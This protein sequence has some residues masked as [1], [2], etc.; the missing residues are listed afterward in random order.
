MKK[1]ITFL[2]ILLMAGISFAWAQNSTVTGTVSDKTGASLPG[3]TVRVKGTQTGTLT[4]VN[5]KYSISAPS[6]AVLIFSFIGF[7]T[8]EVPVGNQTFINVTLQEST[9]GLNEVVVVGYGTQTKAL[10]TGAISTVSAK[11]LQDQQIT[12][13]DDALQGRAAGVYVVQSSGAPGAG[14]SVTIRGSNSLINSSPLYV[15]DGVV[16]DNGG[17]DLVNPN[18]VESINVLKD[19]SAAIYGSRASNGVILITTKKGRSGTPKITYDFYYGTQS[20]M[21]KIGLANGTQYATLRNEAVTNDGGTAPFANPSSFGVGTNWQDLIFGNAPIQSQTLSISGGSETSNYYTSIGYLD[22]KGIVEPSASDYKRLNLKV[23]ATLHPKK[24]F[25]LG[26]NFSYSYSRST[27]FFNTNSEFGG[28]L[29]DAINLDPLTPAV[30]TDINSQPNAATYNN[31]AQFIVRNSLGQP[32]GISA[33]V[34][35]EIVNPLAAIQNVTGNYNW[36]HNLVGDIYVEIEPVKGL[37]LRTEIAGKQAFYG[38][39]AFTPLYYLNQQ[40]SNLITTTQ[41]RSSNQNL[42]WNWDNTATYSRSFGLHSVT[43]LIGASAEEESGRGDNI[44]FIGEP[45]F[46]SATAS[47]NYSLPVASRQAGGFDSQPLTRASEF[48]RVNYDYD[49]KYLFTGIVRRDGSSKFGSDRIYGVFPSGQLGWVASKEKFFPKDAFVSYLKVRASYG[50]LGNELA[51][52]E[53]YFTPIISGGGGGSTVINNQL[54]NGLGPNTLANPLLQWERTKSTDIA[55][56]AILFRDFNL[57][58]DIYDKKT[59]NLIEQQ[60]LPAY[61]GLSS[62]PYSNVGGIDNK[63]IE[64]ELGYNKKI[65]NDLG[66]SFNG[67]LS[68]NK[69]SVTSLGILQF[70]DF[71]SFQSSAYSLQRNVVGQPQNSFYGFQTI[72]IFQSQAEINAY[73]DAAGNVIQP[74]AK[75]GDF[76]FADLSGNGPLS[77]ADRTFLGNPIPSWTYGFNLHTNYKQFDLSAFGQGV[78]GNKIFQGYRRLDLGNANYP[79]EA[80]TA[81]TPTNTNTS[82]PRLT[83]ADPNGNFTKPSN[84]YLQSGAYFRIKT[85]QLGYT[86]PKTLASKWDIEKCRIYVSANNLATITKYNG[87]DPEVAGGIERGV[88]PQA[89]TL[90]VGLDITL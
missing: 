43:A 6:G 33:Y 54:V 35:N 81:W 25:T 66:F 58:V 90:I 78:W 52:G 44:A 36:S 80:L 14:P 75:P 71:G 82:Y 16:W 72:G 57:T 17:Y 46:T 76:K 3:V 64:F 27:T 4:G 19:A 89:R 31:N 11:D 68:Y 30:V 84:F 42:E 22:Q 12:R 34:P 40:S 56:D 74:N 32:Y 15:I 51:L 83:V 69:N 60:P 73:K 45:A 7:T 48:A 61:A 55:F 24:W 39:E 10:S 85:L 63:G 53:F 87:F 79:I 13:I 37:K 29:S 65:T 1:T 62:A 5:G 23:N 70:Q 59:D 47:F 38:T 86:L 9:T 49:G 26:E 28:P 18:D 67:N 41:T 8:Q 88:Y 2:I 21:K 50:V 77:A 20:V